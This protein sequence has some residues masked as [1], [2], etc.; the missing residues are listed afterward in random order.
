MAKEKPERAQSGSERQESLRARRAMEGMREVRGLYLPLDMHET[1]KERARRLLG[2]N[3]A[4]R[5]R[6]ARLRAAAGA[7]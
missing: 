6:R 2:R 1:F 7:P 3:V 4:Q 5:A